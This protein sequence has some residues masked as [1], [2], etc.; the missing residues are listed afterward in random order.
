[1][2][3][4][5]TLR[6]L[7]KLSK[8]KDPKDFYFFG[9]EKRFFAT[10]KD[11]DFLLVSDTSKNAPLAR[12]TLKPFIDAYNYN[13]SPTPD[14]D[15]SLENL[16][17]WLEHS[18]VL[19]PDL[20]FDVEKDVETFVSEYRNFVKKHTATLYKKHQNLPSD[21]SEEIKK[22]LLAFSKNIG[23]MLEI[24]LAEGQ[25]FLRGEDV[26]KLAIDIPSMQIKHQ[27]TLISKYGGTSYQ[28]SW[29]ID[30][31]MK[32]QTQDTEISNKNILIELSLVD[33]A[34]MLDL[35]LTTLAISNTQNM[36]SLSTKDCLLDDYLS[37]FPCRKDIPSLDYVCLVLPMNLKKN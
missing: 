21:K 32:P 20:V 28:K 33:F 8:N 15:P 4:E 26:E 9:Q 23:L 14:L 22:N 13:P 27:E 6:T 2:K 10:C 19:K 34:S 7:I 18:M 24:D 16:S 1:M 29:S 31:L 36:K 17:A 12:T 35:G 3:F 30:V 5:D 37:F 25:L 11:Y